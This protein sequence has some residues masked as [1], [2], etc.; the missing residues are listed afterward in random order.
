MGL[1][2]NSNTNPKRRGRPSGSNS[3][4]RIRLSDLMKIV[5]DGAVVPVSRIW[6]RDNGIEANQ[7]VAMI[8]VPNAETPREEKIEF[9][10]T[11][12]D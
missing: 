1:D 8:S 2:M 12:F 5:G 11:S 10:L 7:P 6:L 9:S 3:F 4:V